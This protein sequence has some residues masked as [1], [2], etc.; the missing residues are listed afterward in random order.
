MPPLTEGALPP[1]ETIAGAFV[2]DVEARIAA[3]E[4]SPDTAA[5]REARSCATRS[6]SAGSCS[7]AGR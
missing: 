1:P 6:G 2:R 5:A 3:L 7:P 4:G